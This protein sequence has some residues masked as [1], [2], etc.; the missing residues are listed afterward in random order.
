[1]HEMRAYIKSSSP[2]PGHQEVMLPGEPDYGRRAQRMRDGIPVE[3]ALWEQIRAAAASV[4]VK[5]PEGAVAAEAR[6]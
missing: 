1:M 4:G 3:D 2:A 6:S 5:W